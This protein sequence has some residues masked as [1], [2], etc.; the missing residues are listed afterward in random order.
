MIARLNVAQHA[1]L[2]GA[3]PDV[4][5]ELFHDWTAPQVNGAYYGLGFRGPLIERFAYCVGGV[6]LRGAN[7]SWLAYLRS[8]VYAGFVLSAECEP[9]AERSKKPSNLILTRAYGRR[10]AQPT[11]E[12]APRPFHEARVKVPRHAAS[13]REP[14]AQRHLLDKFAVHSVASWGALGG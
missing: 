12:F 2:L 8:I 14:V 1:L 5:D 13:P 4:C 7:T 3:Y 6:R 10:D 9:P 11:F